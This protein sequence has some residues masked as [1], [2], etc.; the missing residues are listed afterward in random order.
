MDLPFPYRRI[1]QDVLNK[2]ADLVAA[3]LSQE[4]DEDKD[5]DDDNNGGEHAD[6]EEDDTEEEENEEE[7]SACVSQRKLC[8]LCPPPG[9]MCLLVWS[10]AFDCRCTAARAAQLCAFFFNFWV[11]NSHRPG[12]WPPGVCNPYR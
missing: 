11:I 4:E 2:P 3:I 6:R 12:G 7:V 10:S 1:D 9:W 5:T 8:Q